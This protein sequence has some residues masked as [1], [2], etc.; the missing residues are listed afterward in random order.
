[1]DLHLDLGDVRGPTKR[2]RLETALRDAVRGGRLAPGTKLPPTRGLC[3][4]L[5][6][7]RG[8]VV[9]AYAQLAAEGYLQTRRG[10]GTTV[11]ELAA[12]APSRRSSAASPASVRYD[13]NPFAP[14][15]AQFPR[16]AW[17]SALTQVLRHVPDDRLGVPDPAGVPELRSALAAYL[18]RARGVRA[19]PD[20]IVIT[21]GTRLAIGLVWA[22]LARR[23]ATAIAIEQPGWDGVRDTV[24]EAGLELVPLPVDEH[25]AAVR[26]LAEMPEVDAVAVA[27]AH[28]YPTGAMLSAARRHELLAWAR[29]RERLIVE[30]DYDAEYRYDRQ[31]LGCLQGLAPEHVAYAGSTSKTLAPALR[32]GWIVLPQALSPV[33]I[34]TVRARGTTSSP[35]LQLAL[36]RL[37]ERGDLDRHLRRQRRRYRHRREAL[38]EALAERLPLLRVT[39][40]SAGLFAVLELPAATDEAAVAAAAAARG[41]SLEVRGT[42]PGALVLGYANLAPSAAAGAVTELAAAIESCR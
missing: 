6:V 30:D 38:L 40:A 35:I 32:L 13:L 5:G 41:V 22:A 34:A 21:G 17:S 18:G 4:Q 12:P 23:G 2:A 9:D 24:A 28:Q 37:I 36:A 15:L 1:V 16:S 42:S 33:V 11:A 25:G 26:R 10:G 29:Q 7:S 39:G 27:P 3:E 14:A 31:P 8:V 19:D 20:R